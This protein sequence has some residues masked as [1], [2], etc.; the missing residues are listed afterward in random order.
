MIGRV[1]RA[2]VSAGAAA[3]LSLGLPAVAHADDTVV[4]HG[5]DFPDVQA[6]L[7]YVGCDDIFVRDDQ[8]LAPYIGFGP[9]RAPSGARSLGYDLAGGTAVGSQHLVSSVLTTNVVT[10]SVFAA[11]GSTGRAVVGYQ[12][13]SDSGTAVMWFG[14]A[15]ISA[16]AGEWATVAATPRAYTWTKYEMSDRTVLEQATGDPVPVGDFVAAHGGD[17]PGLYA[18]TFGCDGAPFSMDAMRV[19]S[20]G[21]VTTYDLE[22]LYTWLSISASPLVLRSGEEVTLRGNLTTSNGAPIAHA[23]VIL[24]RL[25]DRTGTWENIRVVAAEDGSP[26]AKLTPT[27]SAFYRWRFVDRPLAEGS[28]SGVFVVT[29]LQ[30]GDPVPVP[31]PPTPSPDET[32]PPPTPDPETPAPDPTTDPSPS[33]GGTPDPEPSSSP[34]D[35]PSTIEDETE[36]PTPTMSPAS[37]EASATA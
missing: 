33:D 1:S 15:P 19:G 13:P 24:E 5:T 17:G 6:Q 23:T 27:Q 22:G 30:P 37:A 18:I 8:G 26:V 4:V 21:D 14:V 32:T 10:L 28:T 7:A 9:G 2:L 34:S 29:V 35:P 16:P 12:A 31:T 11:S 20:P 25:N 36:G 3:A